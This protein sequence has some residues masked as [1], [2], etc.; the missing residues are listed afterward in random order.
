MNDRPLVSIIINNYNYGRFLGKAIDSALNQTYPYIEVVV[1]DDGSTDNSQEIIASYE[2][3]IISV[4]KENGGQASAFNA[5][6]TTSSGEIICLLDSDDLFLSEKVAEV[7]NVFME[8]QDIGWCFHHLRFVDDNTG[9]VIQLSS[10]NGS[11]TCDFR[12]DLKK[13]KLPF[14]LPATSGL[15]FARSLL[16]L[17][18]PMPVA[19]GITLSDQYLKIGALALSQ[20][21]FLDKKLGVVRVHN[22]NRYTADIVRLQANDG[23]T[24][25]NNNQR[26]KANISILTAYYMRLNW[27][28]LAKLANNAFSYG[29]GLS[30]KVG[31]V[32]AETM[33]IAKSY[34]SNISPLEKLEIRTRA[35]YHRL[36]LSVPVAV[37]KAM[38]ML[39]KAT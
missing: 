31:G 30:W 34:L 32:E 35:F 20:G 5:G 39:L 22:S 9:A 21:Y 4:L 2:E 23:Y 8:H 14:S 16:R 3:Q 17:I 36:K 10:E 15:C 18:L 28:F 37:T 25:S 1:V 29:L 13:G 33:Q 12:T 7:V 6:F 26:L 38:N 24:V 19:S 11:R 27:P